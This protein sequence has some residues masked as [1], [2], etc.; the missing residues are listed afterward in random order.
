MTYPD[1][2][3][4]G[5]IEDP[6]PVLGRARL[7]RS[8]DFCQTYVAPVAPA[9]E[10]GLSRGGSLNAGHCTGDVGGSVTESLYR[11]LKVVEGRLLPSCDDEHTAHDVADLNSVAALIHGGDVEDDQV[12][13][14]LLNGASDSVGVD[15]VSRWPSGD[16]RIACDN[17]E[18]RDFT[19]E[20]GIADAGAT[21]KN[22]LHRG[23]CRFRR[24]S[25]SRRPRPLTARSVQ[26]QEEDALAAAREGRS[27][28][29]RDFPRRH[30]GIRTSH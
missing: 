5:D 28:P 20:R 15:E 29:V 30:L 24:T 27:Q 18:S 19:L 23:T 14:C 3:L 2:R 7:I 21:R 13:G 12:G 22:G 1:R 25:L 4:I 8:L 10:V 11:A 26:V 17:A 9:S 16:L 6:T